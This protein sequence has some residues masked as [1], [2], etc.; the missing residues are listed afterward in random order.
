METRVQ[1]YRFCLYA[2]KFWGFHTRGEAETLSC[3]QQAV[4][5]LLESENKRNSILQMA[6]YADWTWDRLSF[7]KGQTMLHVIATNGLAT[8]C[9]HFLNEKLKYAL[10]VSGG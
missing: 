3:I 5:R 10:Y 2:A 1:T 7:T 8:I 6:R 9:R 4:F